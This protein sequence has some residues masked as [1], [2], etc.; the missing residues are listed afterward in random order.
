MRL[1]AIFIF[2]T[3]RLE[4]TITLQGVSAWQQVTQA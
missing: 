4:L 1:I 3:T 2:I